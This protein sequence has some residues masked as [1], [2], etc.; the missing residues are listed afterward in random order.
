MGRLK[1]SGCPALAVLSMVF[2]MT[3]STFSNDDAVLTITSFGTELVVTVPSAYGIE[4]HRGPDFDVH[5]IGTK[6]PRGPV[7]GIYIGHHPNLFSS[8][9][10]GTTS[11]KEADTI[12]GQKVEWIIWQGKEN[13][14]MIRH[15]ETIVQEVFTG[16]GSRSIAALMIHIFIQGP[17]NEEVTS[18]RTAAKSLR[19]TRP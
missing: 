11:E 6:D 15:C 2:V 1:N 18:L 9:K 7:M 17:A 16:S 19:V 10:T 12:L 13:D 4:T 8:R 5:Y 3:T 14:E